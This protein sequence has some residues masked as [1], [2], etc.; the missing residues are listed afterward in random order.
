MQVPSKLRNGSS[1]WIVTSRGPNRYVDEAWQELEELPHDV[2]M[3]SYFRLHKHRKIDRDDATRTIE[4]NDESS[5]QS[6]QPD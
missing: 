1:S 3:V 6:V 2:E 5:F 4:Y